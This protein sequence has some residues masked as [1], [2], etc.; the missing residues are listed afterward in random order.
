MEN[1]GWMLLHSIPSN[2]NQCKV[3]RKFFDSLH[4]SWIHKV[5]FLHHFP[6]LLLAALDRPATDALKRPTS[7]HLSFYPENGAEMVKRRI[8]NLISFGPILYFS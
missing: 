3:F 1:I 6:T 4:R 7:F 5:V 2:R 8:I